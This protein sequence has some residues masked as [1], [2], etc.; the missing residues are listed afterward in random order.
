MQASDVPNNG[1]QYPV[2]A[3]QLRNLL[4]IRGYT[5]NYPNEYNVQYGA[6][7]SR[8][9]PGDINLTVGYTGS[10]GKD[11]FLRG[12]GNVLDPVTRARLVP[13]YGQ[14]DFKTAG[15]VDGISPRRASTR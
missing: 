4:S 14:I 3:S 6:S 13:N 1:L 5:H 9:L 10:Q 2:P 11:M 8:E 7:L 12:V 15:C